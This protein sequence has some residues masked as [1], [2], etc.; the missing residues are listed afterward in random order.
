MIDVELAKQSAHLM[1]ARAEAWQRFIRV[2][3]A[4]GAA[5]P[6]DGCAHDAVDLQDRC[7]LCGQSVERAQ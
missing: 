3:W 5:A 6:D 7:R 2:V 1:Q 4:G